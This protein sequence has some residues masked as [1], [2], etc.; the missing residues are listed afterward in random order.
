MSLTY[1]FGLGDEDTLYTSDQFCAAVKA[2]TGDGVTD[3]YGKRFS[4]SVNGFT[5]IIGTGFVF[6]DGRY[7]ENDEEIRMQV[8]LPSNNRDRTDAIVAQVNYAERKASLTI[9]TNVNEAEIRAN[10]ASIRQGDTYNCI[11]YFIRISRGATSIDPKN[12]IDVRDNTDLCGIVFPLSELTH[13]A[14]KVYEYTTVGFQRETQAILDSVDQFVDKSGAQLE[15]LQTQINNL[16]VGYEVGQ[17]ITVRRAPQP[18]N[19]WLLCDGA[20]V[21]PIYDLL[22]ELI[23]VLPN[24]SKATDRYRTYIYAGKPMET[25]PGVVGRARVGR[26]IVME[27]Q[28]GVA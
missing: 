17:L 13:Q 23:S 8:P 22:S 9:L 1:G 4:V 16:S 5:V 14:Y 7:V 12:I 20:Q 10:P 24:I 19:E 2:I 11:L 15:A 25:E 18:S 6:S 3:K 27:S 21:P 28:E 26:S